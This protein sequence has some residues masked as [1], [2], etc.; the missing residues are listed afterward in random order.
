MKLAS[1]IGLTSTSADAAEFSGQAQV[2][3]GDTVIVSVARGVAIHVRLKGVDV[4]ERETMRGDEAQDHARHRQ[5]RHPREH[6]G[7][8]SGFCF[9]ADGVDIDREI[10]AR[11]A[12][13]ACPRYSARYL[14][15]ERPMALALQPRANHER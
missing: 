15:F 7:S 12:L 6:L 5:R 3:D 2:I 9:T 1:I 11:G 13:L 14:L 10:I 4:A 8:P